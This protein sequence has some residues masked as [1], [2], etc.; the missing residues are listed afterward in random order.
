MK[1]FVCSCGSV[2]TLTK[3]DTYLCRKCGNEYNKKDG[4]F[5]KINKGS[6]KGSCRHFITAEEMRDGNISIKDYDNGVE[7]VSSI[8]VCPNCKKKYQKE[9]IILETEKEQRA[10]LGIKETILTDPIPYKS[11]EE[12]MTLSIRY[13]IEN[14]IERDKISFYKSKMEVKK[15]YL[16]IFEEAVKECK[17]WEIERSKLRIGG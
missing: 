1:N 8:C 12:L 3:N 14:K 13:S 11:W 17:E 6:I 9:G 7:C 5:I 16:R 4:L 15:E 2:V 10:W